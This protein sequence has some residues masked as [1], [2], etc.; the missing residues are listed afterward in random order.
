M[1]KRQYLQQ[2]MWGKL[3]SSMQ[4]KE[5]R[6]LSYMLHKKLTEN[7]LKDFTLKPET[8]KHLEENIS[9][10]FLDTDLHVEFLDLTPK[11]K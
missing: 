1:G 2:M 11:A 8:V 4:K 3:D 7:G 9:G 6:P 10:K 5:N